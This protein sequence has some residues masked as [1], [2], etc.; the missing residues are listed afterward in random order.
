MV[1]RKFSIC[2]EKLEKILDEKYPECV[3]FLL[4]CAAYNTL[5]SLKRIDEAKIGEIEAYLSENQSSWINDLSCCYNEEYKNQ[6]KFH[7]L[8]GHKPILRGFADQIKQ[9]N[10]LK[11]TTS[12]AKDK[13]NEFTDDELIS[14]NG[15]IY[16]K[17]DEQHG[18][19]ELYSTTWNNQREKHPQFRTRH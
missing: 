10:D 18:Q 16:F 15:K 13:K 11:Q 14:V 5:G 6:E 8:P 9:M 2:W 7:F 1:K 17:S 4:E 19:K 12:V 3:K